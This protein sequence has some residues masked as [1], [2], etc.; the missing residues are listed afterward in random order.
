METQEQLRERISILEARVSKLEI[1][2]RL[3]TPIISSD[4]KKK[5]SLKE[6]MM[7]KTLSNDVQRA[8]AI[9]YYFEKYEGFTSFSAQDIKNGFKMAK[10]S[11]P[12][13][14][15]DKINLNIK[16][17]FIMDVDEKKE[18]TKAWTLTT[19]GIKFVDNGFATK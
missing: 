2:S 10:E 7:S 6:F 17:G 12:T 3:E 4:S 9:A 14:V 1:Q 16:K 8:L 18:N 13:N 5:L 15:N 19:S 11:P